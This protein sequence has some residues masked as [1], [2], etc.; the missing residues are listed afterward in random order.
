MKTPHF[1]G[2]LTAI[3]LVCV[4]SPIEAQAYLIG[5][6]VRAQ[7]RFDDFALGGVTTFVAEGTSDLMFTGPFT[8]NVESESILLQVSPSSFSCFPECEF[9][10]LD[11]YDLNAG[12]NPNSS[13]IDV[14]LETNFPGFTGDRVTNGDDIVSFNFN[15]LTC[16]ISNCNGVFVNAYITFTI[17]EIPVAI[18]L[19]PGS[20]EN[21]INIGSAGVIPVA[22]L[23]SET[24]D[25]TN[26]NED[27]IFLA[28][29]SVK[30]A[31]TSGDKFSCQ[32]KDVNND[33]LDDL[34][35]QIETAEFMIEAGDD[36]VELT[37]ETFDNPPIKIKGT[38]SIRIVPD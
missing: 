5:D 35:C 2:F 22:I 27:T 14:V 28:G 3:P 29:A 12:G 4:L 16:P 6:Q 34:V 21:V 20:A 1:F 11:V 13:I 8:I 32:E 18:D 9:N 30:I 37:A 33:G 19:K 15:N 38:D 10:G 17:P 26:V 31:G 25:A 7:L 23:S 36:M 24:F